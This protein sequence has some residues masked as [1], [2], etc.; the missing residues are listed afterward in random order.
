MFCFKYFLLSLFIASYLYSSHN[1]AFLSKRDSLD[2][3]NQRCYDNCYWMWDRFPFPHLL[4]QWILNYHS[5]SLGRKIL[6]IGSG[7]G[8]LALWLQNQGFDVLCL[9]PSPVMVRQCRSKELTCLQTSFQE[10]QENGS[11]STILAILS[12]IHIPKKEWPEQIHKVARL[13]TSNGLFILALIEGESEK[14]DEPSLKF[15]RFFAYFK[16]EEV[17]HLTEQQFELLNFNSISGPEAT[18]LLFAFRKR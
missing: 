9:D 7:T 13:L 3:L 2:A 5:P 15:P 14:I 12:F 18:Y 17:L 1:M 4:P 10:Y 8:Q 16:R 11:F 6:D